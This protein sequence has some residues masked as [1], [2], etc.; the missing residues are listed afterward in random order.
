MPPL[1]HVIINA[2]FPQLD[3]FMTTCTIDVIGFSEL[4]C[5]STTMRKLI[6]ASGLHT[7]RV[8]AFDMMMPP[9][10]FAWLCL[11]CSLS[12]AT[13]DPTRIK[14]LDKLTATLMCHAKAASNGLAIVAD[15]LN[16]VRW[17]MRMLKSIVQ[18]VV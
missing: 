8:I 7:A 9:E 14:L 10:E 15:G 18:T 6:V 5:S 13:T 16:A 11:C 4:A 17:I 12:T 1:A 3:L 2:M